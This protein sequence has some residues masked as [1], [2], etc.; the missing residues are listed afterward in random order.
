LRIWTLLVALLLVGGAGVVATST[1][2]AQ[3]NEVVVVTSFPKEVFEGYKRAF[4]GVTPGVKVVIKQQQTNQGVTYLRETRA[5]PD[6]D[7]F[8]VS[9]V[10]AFLSLK[11]DGCSIG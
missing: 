6:A 2:W 11:Q 10:D 3:S 4:E 5:K 1:V 7:V 9:S 8:W